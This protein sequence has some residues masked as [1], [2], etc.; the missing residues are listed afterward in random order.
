MTVVKESFLVF[1]SLRL[2]PHL[3]IFSFMNDKQCIVSDIQKWA[4]LYYGVDIST[5]FLVYRYLI[6][7]MT[8]RPPF[9]NLFYY[10]LRKKYPLSFLAP[11]IFL[12]RAKPMNCKKL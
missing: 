11:A 5:S 3:I 6:I 10:R 9:R 8:F 4:K 12:T 1:S 7:L 2:I